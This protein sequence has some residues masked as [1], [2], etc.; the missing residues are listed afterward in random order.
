MSQK[1]T[2]AEKRQQRQKTK[3]IKAHERQQ[4]HIQGGNNT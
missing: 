4:R 2:Y 1:M 3:R